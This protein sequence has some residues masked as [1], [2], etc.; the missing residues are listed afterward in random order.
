[1]CSDI[2]NAIQTPSYSLPCFALVQSTEPCNRV[3]CD[4][5]WVYSKKKKKEKKRCRPYMRSDMM[6][7]NKKTNKN[8]AISAGC[9]ACLSI[10]PRERNVQRQTYCSSL[11]PCSSLQLCAYP[12]ESWCTQEAFGTNK[13]LLI[14]KKTPKVAPIPSKMLG[15][16]P[17]FLINALVVRKR[18]K[19]KSIQLNVRLLAC[20]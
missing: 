3:L 5:A 11:C 6:L 13:S 10:K 19:K 20:V 14:K 8:K 4:T 1:M 7:K 18:K 17:S 2:Q 15:C 12:N 16:C 9:T